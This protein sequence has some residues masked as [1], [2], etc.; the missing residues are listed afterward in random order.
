MPENKTKF[1][2]QWT[3]TLK[4]TSSAATRN[5]RRVSLESP[6]YRVN[7]NALSSAEKAIALA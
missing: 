6:V 3:L 7:F 5:R 1:L 4:L 2:L